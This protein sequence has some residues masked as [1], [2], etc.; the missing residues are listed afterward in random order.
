MSEKIK[1]I[2]V[3]VSA[4]L[5]VCMLF[6]FVGFSLFGC[7]TTE[8]VPMVQTNTEHHWHTDSVKEK[9]SVYH[10]TTTI[11]QQLDS[12]AMAKYG[13]QLKAAERAWLVKTAELERQIER[14][15]AMNFTKDSVH[16]SIPVPVEVVKEVAADLSWWQRLRLIL[17]DFV[18]LAIIGLAGYWGIRLYKVYKFF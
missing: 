7:S 5:V 14:L 17:G 16:D 2:L 8:Y 10:E 1:N 9:D 13:I 15:Q 6:A 3:E 11:I 18:L 12:A 4:W